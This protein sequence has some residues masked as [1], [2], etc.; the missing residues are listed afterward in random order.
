MNTKILPNTFI[1]P[2]VLFVVTDF[3]AAVVRHYKLAAEGR[4]LAARTS[5]GVSNS[6]NMPLRLLPIITS[7]APDA[8]TGPNQGQLI[9]FPASDPPATNWQITS[10]NISLSI[11]V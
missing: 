9:L 1:S 10:G 7:D 11:S 4:L 3:V 2:G 8:A 6:G 5:D